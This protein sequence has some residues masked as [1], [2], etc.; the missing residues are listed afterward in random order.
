MQDEIGKA[1][2][3]SA[4][5]RESLRAQDIE[6][7]A[8]I[9][10]SAYKA[11]GKVLIAGNGGSAADSQHMAAELVGRY[12]RERP[13]LPAV[14]LTTDS[15]ILTALANDYGAEYMFARQVEALGAG[16][17]VLVAFSTSGASAN[18]IRAVEAARK[19]RMKVVGFTG[20]RGA[21]LKG[22]CDACI[23]VD[24]AETPRIQEAHITAAHIICGLVEDALTR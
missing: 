22:L 23:T 2:A 16:G 8:R 20:A 6:A 15:S 13:P 18:V 21:K 5:A 10:A 14:A 3:E 1:L 12:V 9:I 17:D 11:G 7:A 19:R 4:K 24:S